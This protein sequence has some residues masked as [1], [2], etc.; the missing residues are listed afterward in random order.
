MYDGGLAS[1]AVASRDA[2]TSRKFEFALNR[3]R[4]TS[5]ERSRDALERPSAHAESIQIEAHM[6]MA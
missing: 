1:S 4:K 5:V 2:L 3:G 6:M